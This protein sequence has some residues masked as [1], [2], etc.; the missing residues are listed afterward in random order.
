LPQANFLA[1]DL[2]RIARVKKKETAATDAAK[3]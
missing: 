1:L 3:I 2:A